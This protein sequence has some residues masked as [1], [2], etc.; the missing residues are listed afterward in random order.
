MRHGSL[1]KPSPSDPEV[2]GLFGL[3][4]CLVTV[5]DHG[6]QKGHSNPSSLAQPSLQSWLWVF[7]MENSGRINWWCTHFLHGESQADGVAATSTLLTFLSLPCQPEGL[8]GSSTSKHFAPVNKQN[9]TGLPGR[10]VCRGVGEDTWS[11]LYSYSRG[12]PAERVREDSGG[13]SQPRGLLPA[14]HPPNPHLSAC[15]L[16]NPSSFHFCGGG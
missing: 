4:F 11:G 13:P 7:Q 15:L 10:C 16:N 6:P 2:P 1:L 8:E 3:L 9:S 12:V 5:S 14:T